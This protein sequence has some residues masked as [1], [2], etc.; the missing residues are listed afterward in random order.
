MKQWCMLV[1]AVA[2][3]QLGGCATRPEPVPEL[4]LADERGM[5]SP[6]VSQQVS[7][8]ALS[9]INSAIHIR[10]HG[11]LARSSFDSAADS[12]LILSTLLLE[13][14]QRADLATANESIVQLKTQMAELQQSMI[15]E[16]EK[17]LKDQAYLHDQIA[18]QLAD[19]QRD[20]DM[21]EGLRKRSLEEIE[22][23]RA[24]TRQARDDLTAQQTRSDRELER[25][26]KQNEALAKD[27]AK[28]RKELG[29]LQ[30]QHQT[31][32]GRESGITEERN[33]LRAENKEIK[34]RL[35]ALL[36]ENG[37][38]SVQAEQAPLLARQLEMAN[39]ELAQLKSP[40]E[41]DPPAAPT[42][43]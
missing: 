4:L 9:G 16:R 34:V 27:L 31:V 37:R 21:I 29:E 23:A 18:A 38:L 33:R 17:A 6:I 36:L 10:G 28:V 43:G 20:R 5:L 42:A 24:E 14:N 13:D 25:A 41:S 7:N 39:E 30:L 8:Q 2:M 12:G 35:D 1:L 26:Q 11:A 22:A 40:Q 3:L 32:L 19:R 15:D